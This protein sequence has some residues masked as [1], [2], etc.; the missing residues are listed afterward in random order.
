VLDEPDWDRMVEHDRPN[1]DAGPAG[2]P[3]GGTAVPVEGLLT[4]A[5]IA[6]ALRVSRMTIYRLVERGS[7]PSVRVGHSIRVPAAAVRAYLDGPGG[8]PRVGRE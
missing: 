3:T 6:Q 8:R 1:G 2:S 5:E 7:L 4:V